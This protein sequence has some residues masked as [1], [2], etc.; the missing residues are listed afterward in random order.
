MQY[1]STRGQSPKVS[2]AEVVRAGL[3][4]DG[5][6]Y[7]P[8]SIPVL[9]DMSLSLMRRQSFEELSRNIMSRYIDGI[10]P[11]AL[12][13]IVHNAF[14]PDIFGS[15]LI[16]PVDRIARGQYRLQLSNGPT[17]AFKDVGLRFLSEWMR[18]ALKLSGEKQTIVGATSGDTGPAAL[19]A[20]QDV[21]GIETVILFPRI[22]MS[23]FQRRQMTTIASTNVHCLSI[24]GTFD[25]CQ[26]IVK[27][28]FNDHVFSKKHSV[29]AIN[30]I[31]WARILA[32]TI[33]YFSAYFQVTISDEERVTFSVPTGNFGDI[34]AGLVARSMGLPIDF[35]LATNENDVLRELFEDGIYRPRNQNEMIMA[36]SAS[37]NISRASNLER[38]L[39]LASG[40]DSNLIASLYSQIE[41]SES[42]GFFDIF[43]TPLLDRLRGL[44]ITARTSTHDDRIRMAR[45]IYERQG[46][47]IDPHTADGFVAAEMQRARSSE[48]NP[49]VCLETALPVKFQD[50]VFEATGI[51]PEMPERF[52]SM[53]KAPERS[54]F[55]GNSVLEVKEYIDKH[56]GN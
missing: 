28:I 35:I 39:W 23:E 13:K 41:S 4:P 49:I 38:A 15:K 7:M 56:I 22:G 8:E 19:H 24:D 17:A 44:G 29:G 12:S 34:M 55:L 20:L 26:A 40:M 33:Y 21:P 32:Q 5:G 27:A 51:R 3:A 30:S 16:T 11:F 18:Y 46:I 45:Y 36:D 25:D 9:S 48:K 1:V 54:T 14:R 2:F 47:I 53:M 52:K 43:G 6:L 10:S 37:M 31:N 42:Q 50:F